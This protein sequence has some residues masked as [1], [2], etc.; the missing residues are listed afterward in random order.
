MANAM[1]TAAELRDI[2]L[3]CDKLWALDKNRLEP[4]VDY[5]LNLQQG[6][7][8]WQHGD[9]TEDPL[10]TFVDQ[11]VFERPTFR[12]F[13][14]LLDNYERGVGITETVTADELTENNAFLNAILDTAPMRYVYNWLTKNKKFV[15][16]MSAFK[17]KLDNIWFG[18]YRRQTRNDSSGFEHV[19][20]GEEKD[21][22]ICGCHNWIQIYHEERAG[23]LNYLGYIKPKQRGQSVMKPFNTEQLVTI[24]FMWEKEIKPVSTSLVGVSPEFEMALYTLCFLNGKEDNTVKLGP[25]LANI[26]CFTFGRGSDTKIG[27]AFPETLP[28]TTEQAAVKIQ[29]IARG[30]MTR[31]TASFRVEQHHHHHHH[32][33]SSGNG[34][35]PQGNAWGQPRPASNGNAPPTKAWGQPRPA[36]RPAAPA[37]LTGDAWGPALSAEK[38]AAPA[39]SDTNAGGAWAKPHKCSNLHDVLFR[40]GNWCYGGKVD[41]GSASVELSDL[42]AVIPALQKQQASLQYLC[43]WKAMPSSSPY[44]T[45]LETLYDVFDFIGAELA[46]ERI[47]RKLLSAASEYPWVDEDSETKNFFEL[48]SGGYECFDDVDIVASKTFVRG[49]VLLVIYYQ[50][51]FYVVL[52]E[53]EGEQPLLDVRFPDLTSHL[54]GVHLQ[55]YRDDDCTNM[56]KLTLWQAVKA[57]KHQSP[58]KPVKVQCKDVSGTGYNQTFLIR[59]TPRG[60]GD[61]GGSTPSLREVLF[62][63]GNWCYNGHVDLG[64]KLE[65]PDIPII[66]PMLRRQQ[67]ALTFMCEVSK[68]PATSLFT[69]S[70]EYLAGAV[71]AI[72]EEL[73]KAEKFI[74]SLGDETASRMRQWLDDDN[75]DCFFEIGMDKCDVLRDVEAIA[76]KIY[77]NGIVLVMLYYDYTFYVYIESGE[78]EQPLLDTNFPDVSFQKEGLQI[79]TY[80]KGV[81]SC[82]ELRRISLWKVVN[83]FPE[84]MSDDADK[85]F[86]NIAATHPKSSSGNKSQHAD[87]KVSE[88]R[89]VEDVKYESPTV[90]V[91][92]DS[93]SVSKS[94]DFSARKAALPHHI[95][96]LKSTAATTL[97]KMPDLGLKAPWDETGKPLGLRASK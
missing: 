38:P 14:S 77:I 61:N 49:L 25:Y 3:A 86:G 97:K 30:R 93:K 75:V 90:F 46:S 35:A 80:R 15:G 9:V 33:Q 71:P 13:V 50:R 87:A 52:Q 88:R 72:Q 37:V 65:L 82:P 43:E 95:A 89:R 36:A 23:R 29:A 74:Q 76:S 62:R 58:P 26:K 39:P 64:P 69:P 84:E 8:M 5:E 24:Q 28:L 85:S 78:E 73:T 70:M 22:K 83:E 59:R 47:E 55:T 32:H 60:S 21:G 19:F 31:M 48:Q 92:S 7:T 66:I 44:S 27:T 18:L 79:K 67:S 68:M 10:F 81:T 91:D 54:Q 6:K 20:L 17:K 4:N 11:S 41:L 96:P 53:G 34:N 94:A 1:P 2:S 51:S 16:D 56:K 42:P 12:H 40:C 45:P 57:S 63:F